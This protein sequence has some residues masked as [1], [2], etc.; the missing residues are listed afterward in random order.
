MRVGTLAVAAIAIAGCGDED[1]EPRPRGTARIELVEATG[2]ISTEPFVADKLSITTSSQCT[3]GFPGISKGS[4]ASQLHIRAYAGPR[5]VELRRLAYG[6]PAS[7]A[8]DIHGGELTPIVELRESST[9]P[10]WKA[11]GVDPGRAAVEIAA[12]GK[13]TFRLERVLL[14]DEDHE[15]SVRLTGAL[16]FDCERVSDELAKCARGEGPTHP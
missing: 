14:R 1:E 2:A 16:I 4:C 9:S 13:T 6:Q 3:G 15:A 5:I 11:G 12:D 8:V 7:G 10:S